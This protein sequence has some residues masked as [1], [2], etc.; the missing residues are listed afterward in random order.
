MRVPTWQACTADP[1]ALC[2][3]AARAALAVSR[4]GIGCAELGVLLADDETLRHLNNAYR[5]QDRA[6]NVLAFPTF[7]SRDQVTAAHPA[8]SPILLGDVVLAYET[9]VAESAAARISLDD[10]LCH[11][12]VHGVLH[13]LGYDHGQDDEAADMQ[14]LEAMA[15]AAIGIADPYAEDSARV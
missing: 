5:G 10:H 3:R 4:A 1:L 7:E 6:T 15:L 9:A 2:D 8:T 14:Q 12:V 13:L 11:L